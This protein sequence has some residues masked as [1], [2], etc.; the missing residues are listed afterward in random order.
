MLEWHRTRSSGTAHAVATS[1][2]RPAAS[3]SADAEPDL[4]AWRAALLAWEAAYDH[5]RPDQALGT[6][7][8]AE[9]L[10]SLGSGV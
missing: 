8:L 5:V 6:L 1:P 3:A 2:V 10:A 4:D 9:F 7:T